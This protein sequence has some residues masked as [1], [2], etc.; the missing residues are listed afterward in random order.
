MPVGMHEGPKSTQQRNEYQEF[1]AHFIVNIIIFQLRIRHR[2]IRLRRDLFF[3][4]FFF[5]SFA[6]LRPHPLLYKQR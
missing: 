5:F 3:S 2:F 6:L 4:F 1:S